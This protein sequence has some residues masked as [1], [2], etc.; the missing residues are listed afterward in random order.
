MACIP[1]DLVRVSTRISRTALERSR[2]AMWDGKRCLSERIKA[3]RRPARLYQLEPSFGAADLSNPGFRTPLALT[4]SSSISDPEPERV[5]HVTSKLG[6][7]MSLRKLG[8]IALTA[9]LAMPAATIV[10]QTAGQD[11]KNAGSD[12]K[13]ATKSAGSGISKGTK[14]AYHKTKRGTKKAYHKVDGN[15]NTK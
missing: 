5:I 15:P 12:T 9:V 1:G 11:M 6:E 3:T 13:S 4:I 10:A 14:K 8:T 7:T 2:R